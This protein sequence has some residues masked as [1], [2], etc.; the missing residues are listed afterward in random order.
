MS[1][2]KRNTF[3]NALENLRFKDISIC[4]NLSQTLNIRELSRKTQLTPGQISKTITK[5]EKIL[6][7]K[8]FNR[9][10]TGLS[11]S[12]DGKIFLP[13]L[14]KLQNDFLTLQETNNIKEKKNLTLACS[15]FFASHLLP[16]IILKF[17]NYQFN[18]IQLPPED[19]IQVGLLSGFSVC[20]HTTKM[21]WPKTWYSELAGN[22]TFKLYASPKHPIFRKKTC[23][24]NDIKNLDFTGPIYWTKEG[25]TNGNDYFPKNIT[26]KILHKTSTAIGSAALI[27]QSNI[28]GFLPSLIGESEFYN[29][30]EINTP[31][32]KPVKQSIYITVKS[33]EISQSF[34]SEFLNQ[35]S[36][37]LLSDG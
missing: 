35:I 22:I 29:L 3:D 26:R 23:S 24:K 37:H 6:K 34:Y 21:D 8:L 16:K 19:Y 30:K 13:K 12:A 31:F 14:Q 27:H 4:L 7:I 32:I 15:S 17:K 25:L 9:S 11:L 18:I 1:L 20:L 36:I 10:T 33:D 28:V 5:L 2:Q